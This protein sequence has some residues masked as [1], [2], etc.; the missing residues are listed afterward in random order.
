MSIKCDVFTIQYSF[1][2]L[3]ACFF[4]TLAVIDASLSYIYIIISTLLLAVF[5]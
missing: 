1:Y 4:R 3:N 5:S 2:T